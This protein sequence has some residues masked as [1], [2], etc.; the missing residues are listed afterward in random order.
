MYKIK[1]MVNSSSDMLK[2]ILAM[3]Y[4]MNIMNTN[5]N[6]GILTTYKIP[7]ENT[8]MI[9]RKLTP[10]KQILQLIQYP[11]G[12]LNVPTTKFSSVRLVRK[13]YNRIR[14]MVFEDVGH[15][16]DV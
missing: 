3:Q 13:R 2:T 12:K 11:T 1:N 14:W 16:Y 6:T 10:Q 5:R 15:G 7:T 4:P 9:R 8:S